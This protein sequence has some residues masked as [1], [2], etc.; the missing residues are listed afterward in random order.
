MTA[1]LFLI[2][3]YAFWLASIAGALVQHDRGWAIVMGLE[4]LVA[5]LIL[6]WRR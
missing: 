6:I 5:T 3:M 1:K 2:L 4:V